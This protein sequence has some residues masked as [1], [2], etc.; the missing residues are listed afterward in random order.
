MGTINKKPTSSFSLRSAS[1]FLVCVA[2]AE[3]S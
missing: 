1:L 2:A 3:A